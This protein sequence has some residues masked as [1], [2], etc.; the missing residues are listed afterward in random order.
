MT[1]VEVEQ[2][3]CAPESEGMS[4]GLAPWRHRAAAITL[5]YLPG[6]ALLVTAGLVAS[7]LPEYSGWWWTC[8]VTGS[9]AMIL[10]ALNRLV[11]PAVSGQSLGRA[12]ARIAVV[13]PTGAPVGAGRLLLRDLVHLLD[14]AAG[15]GGW[16]WP[17]WDRRRRTFADRLLNTESRVSPGQWPDRRPRRVAGAAMLVVALLCGA[18][19]AMSYLTVARHDRATNLASAE[20]AEQGPHIVEKVLSYRPDTF[21]DDFDTARSLV[22][23]N[24]RT[25]LATQQEG[26][27]KS[28]AVRNEYWA[29]NS[30]VLNASTDRGTMLVFLQGQRGA[31]PNVRYIT[32]T[33]RASFVRLHTS[34]WRLDDLAVVTKPELPAAG[35]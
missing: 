1:T 35:P 31:A 10:T 16:L 25:Q 9:V 21:Q 5:D 30:A 19:A 2:A 29:T 7:S 34:E 22:T 15:F 12:V 11:L 32:A 4:G 26:I 8:L 13:R 28:G 18:G 3:P 17:L 20:L 6:A 23:E 14:T 24:Y 33:V 27:A